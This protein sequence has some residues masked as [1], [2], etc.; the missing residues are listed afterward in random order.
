MRDRGFAA[1]YRARIACCISSACGCL[2]QRGQDPAVS[3]Q[4]WDELAGGGAP[5]K[6]RGTRGEA[7]VLVSSV[8]GS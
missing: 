1:L 2:H 5:K 3:A 8:G 7:S 6:H 4:A